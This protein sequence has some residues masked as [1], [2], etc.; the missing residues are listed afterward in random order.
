MCLNAAFFVA[1]HSFKE[2]D[3]KC[4]NCAPVSSTLSRNYGLVHTLDGYRRL[5]IDLFAIWQIKYTNRSLR[6]HRSR[7]KAVFDSHDLAVC[8]DLSGFRAPFEAWRDI[9]DLIRT[10][11]QMWIS[12]TARA[13]IGALFRSYVLDD[14]NLSQSTCAN[15][16]CFAVIMST[17][18]FIHIWESTDDP[19]PAPADFELQHKSTPNECY[20]ALLA[21]G[22]ANLEEMCAGACR[23]VGATSRRVRKRKAVLGRDG[24]SV[25]ELCALSR[26]R[27]HP[28]YVLSYELCPCRGAEQDVEPESESESYGD[29]VNRSI[30]PVLLLVVGGGGTGSSEEPTKF[31]EEEESIERS[32][33][34]DWLRHSIYSNEFVSKGRSLPKS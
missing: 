3:A 17:L 14:A 32:G 28:E 12:D 9:Y 6:I 33:S 19:E 20:L 16:F 13:A 8:E 5:Y 7:L 26:T 25:A 27:Q 34:P 22:T 18:P 29:P 31:D 24:R 10:L 1:S 15:D 2:Y 30:G 4:S 21:T 11:P 23:R